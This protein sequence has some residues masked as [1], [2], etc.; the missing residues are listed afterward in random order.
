MLH[1]LDQS[2]EQI[3]AWMQE[4]GQRPYRAAQIRKWL[5]EKRA[6]SWEQMTDLPKELREQLA[7]E[8]DIWSAE[9]AVHR[10]DDD[11][12]EKLL[13]TLDSSRKS[14]SA[15]RVENDA[16]NSPLVVP[17]SAGR[18][19]I[20]PEGGTTSAAGAIL[21]QPQN[22]PA[23]LQIEC[24]LL[25]DDKGHCSMCISTQ[26]GCAMKCAFC[27]TG[28]GGMSRNLTTG[29]ILEQML[30]LQRLLKPEERLSHI[31]CMGMG[32]PLANLDRLMPALSAASSK[33]G[34]GIGVRKITIS[35]VGLPAGIRRLA[36]QNCQYH[37]AVSL[38]APN[39]ELRTQLMPTN[40]NIGIDAIMAAADEYFERT[41]RRITYEY[42]LLAG[43]NDG[44][45]EASQLVDLLRGRPSLVNLIPYNPVRG[46]KFRTPHPSSVARF[47]ETLEQGGLNVAIRH[48]KGARIDAACGQLRRAATQAAKS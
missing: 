12:T 7:A 25:R 17:A 29:E 23:A 33:A 41:G 10:K 40:R 6:G 9:I 14:P 26:V 5:Y 1:I 15:V 2:V 16:E 30:Q 38:H 35:T 11:G 45:T 22:V 24:V 34:L 27:A 32:E 37:L 13:L 47:V 28:L 3:Q 48:R 36:E 42:I 44:P 21:S 43:V 8:F 4:H 19:R 31:V 18:S 46:L 20:P 39:D